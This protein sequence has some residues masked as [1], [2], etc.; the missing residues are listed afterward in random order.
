[1]TTPLK[2]SASPLEHPRAPT[3]ALPHGSCDSHVH[4]FGPFDRH[5]LPDVPIWTRFAA[6]RHASSGPD[7]VA[8]SAL[9]RLLDTGHGLVKLSAADPPSKTGAPF[10][11]GI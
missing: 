6:W 10:H 11:G 8:I 2:T 9:R 3:I 1:M 5:P 7:G 4:M